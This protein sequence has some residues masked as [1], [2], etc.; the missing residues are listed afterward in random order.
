MDFKAARPFCGFL[1]VTSHH[2]CFLCDCWHISHL[3][4]TDYENWKPLDDELLRKAA[5]QWRNA[6]LKDRK[7]IEELFGTRYSE[8]WRLPYWRLCQMGID[9]MHALF[10]ILLQRYFR[11]ILGLDN[12]GDSKQQRKKPRFK[13]AFHHKFTPPPSLSSLVRGTE[14]PLRRWSSVVGYV[15]QPTDEN[16]L[17]VL[18]W[19]HLSPEHR[20]CIPTDPAVST[21]EFAP[22]E[23]SS[24]LLR[25]IQQVVC[26]IDTP[27]WV[28][29]PPRNVGLYEAGTLKADHWRTLFSIHVPLAILSL[30]K[31]T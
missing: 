9:P 12:P 2:F 21:R 30:W 29:N 17:S 31:D 28:S 19:T 7:A 14:V 16:R 26:E 15:P 6:M 18:D 5:E 24:S 8:L 1:D 4:R 25:R 23:H 3:G 22:R 13:L 11:D 27:T 10:L 20:A